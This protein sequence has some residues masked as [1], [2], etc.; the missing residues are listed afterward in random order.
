MSVHKNPSGGSGAPGSG[1]RLYMQFDPVFFEKTRLSMM[2]LIHQ[3]GAVSFNRFKLLLDGT[4]GA[5]YGHIQKLLK[6]GYIRQKKEIAGDKAQTVY[7][8]TASGTRLFRD[9]LSFLEQMLRKDRERKN[10]AG[11]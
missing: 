6:A 3:E 1:D 2:T 10:D 5:I 8:L 4:D 9:Y 7:S 11:R